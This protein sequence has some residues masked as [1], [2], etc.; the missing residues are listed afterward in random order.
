[1]K[2]HIYRDNLIIEYP[3]GTFIATA[4]DDEGDPIEKSCKSLDKAKAWIDKTIDIN[5]E[6]SFKH[7]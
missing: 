7:E 1:M 4:V 6:A 2:E 5:S 3:D